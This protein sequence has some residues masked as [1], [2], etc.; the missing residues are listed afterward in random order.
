MHRLRKMLMLLCVHVTTLLFLVLVE[1]SAHTLTSHP[2]LCALVCVI[3]IHFNPYCMHAHCMITTDLLH[4]H[5][6]TIVATSRRF[7]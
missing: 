4:T 3:S 5:M 1:N 6:E 2:F 7:E